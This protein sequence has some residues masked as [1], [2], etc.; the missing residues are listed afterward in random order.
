MKAFENLQETL[1]FFGVDCHKPF[2]I[3]SGNPILSFPTTAF[4]MD[5]Y[6]IGF[7]VTGNIDLEIDK[8][9]CTIRQ[10]QFMLSAPSTIVRF[11]GTSNDFKMKLLFFDKNFLLK[12]ISNPFI[13]DKMSLFQNGSYSITEPGSEVRS[14]LVNL[15]AYLEEKAKQQGKFTEEIIR[16][17]IFN[18]L[19]EMAEVIAEQNS[20][21][22]GAKNNPRELYFRFNKMVQENILQCR[23]VQYYA[24]E[25]FVSNKYLIEIVKKA[26]GK[27]PHQVIDEALLKEAYVLLGIPAM[28]ISEIAYKLQF[29]ST[30]AFGRFFKRYAFISPSAYRVR[31]NIRA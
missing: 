15:L 30:S 16:T 14:R 4:R 29:N 2:Y 31:E 25:L 1:A 7:C 17:V 27:S 12:N 28:S 5:Y 10:D 20:P 11:R 13:I 6:V 24:S 9:H 23:D 8:Q 22:P 19:L 3:S 18:L 21:L 26:T